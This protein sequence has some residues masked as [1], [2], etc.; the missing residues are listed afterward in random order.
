MLFTSSWLGASD[1]VVLKPYFPKM[2]C[3]LTSLGL[4]RVSCGLVASD[5]DLGRAAEPKTSCETMW[6]VEAWSMLGEEVVKEF[7]GYF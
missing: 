7:E 4:T 6:I 3:G 2:P 5:Q 1:S